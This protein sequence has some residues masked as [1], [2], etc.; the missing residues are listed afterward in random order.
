MNV[1]LIL[2]KLKFVKEKALQT[3]QSV[4]GLIDEVIAELTEQPKDRFFIVFY[5]ASDREKTINGIAF[6]RGENGEF[7]DF[8]GMKNL[9]N[10]VQFIITGFN[11]ISEKD[12]NF[13]VK[14]NK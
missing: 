10:K 14:T 5:M 8:G 9:I 11:E 4:S 7:I 12:Y 1:P 2:E 13:N 3:P 6:C